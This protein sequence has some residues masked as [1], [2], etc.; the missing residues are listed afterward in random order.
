MRAGIIVF[1]S[2]VVVLFLALLGSE[3]LR[4]YDRALERAAA[5][6]ENLAAVLEHHTTQTTEIVDGSLG[7]IID[8]LSAARGSPRRD[9]KLWIMLRRAIMDLSFVHRIIVVDEAGDIMRDSLKDP[10]AAA[11]IAAESYFT[12]PRDY[13]AAGI[14]ISAPFK[15]AA[16]G[17]W[18]IALSRRL[19]ASEREFAGVI[20][21]FVDLGYFQRIYDTLNIGEGGLIQLFKRDGTTLIREPFRTDIYEQRADH[22]AAFRSL[23]QWTRNGTTTL[24]LPPDGIERIISYRT[25]PK[26]P[27]IVAVGLSRA[28]VLAQWRDDVRMRV[29]LA[30][31]ITAAVVLLMLLLLR[32]LARREAT[33]AALRESQQR[34]ELAV[35][36]TSDGLWDWDMIADKVWFSPRC[37]ELL[38]YKSVD[39][40]SAD[41]DDYFNRIHAEDSERRAA[42]LDRHLAEGKPYDV[43]YRL[44]LKGGGYRWFRVRGQAIRGTDGQPIRMAGSISDI[45]AQRAA[46]AALVETL[47][48]LRE[49]E[50]RLS[51]LIENVP[52]VIYRSVFDGRWTETFVNHA[53][54]ELTGYPP[55]DFIAG[56]ARSLSSIIHPEDRDYFAWA[57]EEAVRKRTPFAVEYRLIHKSGAVK[58]VWDRGRAS[59]TEDGQAQYIDGCIFDITDRRE[60]EAELRRAKEAAEAANQAKS[61]FLAHMSHELRTP[62]NAII[63]FSEVMQAELFGSMGSPQYRAYARDIHESGTHLLGLINDIL[64]LSKVEAGRQELHEEDCDIEEIVTDS[65]RLVAEPAASQGVGIERHLQADVPALRADYRMIKQILLNLLSN[66]I[67]FTPTEGT[68]KLSVG[69][70][71]EGSLRFIVEDNGIGIPSDQVRRVFEPFVQVEGAFTRK[72]GGTGLGLPL[73]RTFVELHGGTLELVSAVGA[74]TTVIVTFPKERSQNRASAA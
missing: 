31:I 9:P 25:V 49:N 69:T 44:R 12:F 41:Y 62:L 66:A 60:G 22:L 19:D 50:A 38:G 54:G 57:V 2:A 26:R 27:L 68:I 56:G 1:G 6:S 71:A 46:E 28:E 67:K 37:C 43:E 18:S 55:T 29:I 15:S 32:S 36:G 65:L 53:L 48:S 45:D 33:E 61:E 34:F 7:H 24:S 20:V 13:A 10:P 70:T 11:N 47:H 5:T 58:W 16:S 23:M 59:Y 42:A 39:E 21:A 3:I 51:S 72:Y 14:Y 35:R 52:G 8:Y 17:R 74:G 40:F 4:E 63:G 30:L 64:D 73:S